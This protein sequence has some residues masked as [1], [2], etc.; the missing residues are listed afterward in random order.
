M[1]SFSD[2]L[3]QLRPCWWLLNFT[4]AAQG[5]KKRKLLRVAN[6]AGAFDGGMRGS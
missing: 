4:K 1:I 5:P 3:A 6:R 2:T